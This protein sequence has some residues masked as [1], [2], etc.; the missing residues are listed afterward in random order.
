[1][2]VALALCVTLVPLP[3]NDNAAGLTGLQL[4]GLCS[5]ESGRTEDAA[6]CR[7]YFRR[8]L[9]AF[10]ARLQGSSVIHYC[11]PYGIG[12]PQLIE[13]Y[14][15][16]SQRYPQVLDEAAERLIAGMVLKFY[17]CRAI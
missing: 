13:L 12:V 6:T 3:A 9:A 7:D 11:L 16:E 8:S 1:M 10:V 4:L 5:A 2:V 14:K 17:P 15:L